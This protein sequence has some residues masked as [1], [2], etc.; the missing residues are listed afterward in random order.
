[1]SFFFGMLSGLLAV[2]LRF[3]KGVDFITTPLPLLTALLIL[4][5]I[6]LLV[7]GLL[8]DILMRSYYESGNI[9]PYTVKKKENFTTDN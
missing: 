2:Y 9:A 8:S 7:M 1:M 3:Y 5:G 4:V 6:Q